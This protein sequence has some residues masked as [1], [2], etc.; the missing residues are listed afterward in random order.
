ML[1]GLLLELWA[2]ISPIVLS[3]FLGFTHQP[4]DLLTVRLPTGT[5]RG[6]I[7]S[8]KGPFVD[9]D[10]S[11]LAQGHPLVEKWLGIP[12]AMPPTGNLRFKAPRPLPTNLSVA[13]LETVQDADS[14]GAACPQ[15]YGDNNLGAPM[16]EDCLYLNV[17]L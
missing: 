5:Y 6:A 2:H 15:P 16:S 12:Y 1:L 17:G 10:G 14:F 11:I 8:P 7:D 9:E 13:D 3:R 4:A